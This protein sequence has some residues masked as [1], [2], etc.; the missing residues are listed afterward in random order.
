MLEALKIMSRDLD[1][2]TLV[3][4]ALLGPFTLAC[5]LLGTERAIYLLADDRGKF[6]D[7]IHFCTELAISYGKAQVAAAGA[8]HLRPGGFAG[9]HA[10]R[11]C[12]GRSRSLCSPN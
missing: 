8:D 2:R 11:H 3:T 4:S 1:G 9:G 5:Q 10:P 12:S 6:M 7:H